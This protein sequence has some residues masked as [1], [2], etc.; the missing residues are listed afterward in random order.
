[1]RYLLLVSHGTFAPGLHSVLDM[2]LGKR[3]DILSCSM[4]DGMGADVFVENLKKVLEPVGADDEVVCFGDII[5]GSPLTN[6]L[7]T[8]TEKGLLPKTTAFGGMNLPMAITAAMG[9]ETPID[10]LKGSIISE[11]QEAIRELEL[12]M[13]EEDEDEI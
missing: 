9:M 10:A 13:G 3:D 11:G 5:G 4:E 6:T 8:L 12:Q 1:M 2:L 7:N